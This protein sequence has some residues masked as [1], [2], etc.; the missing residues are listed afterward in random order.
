MLF[1][2]SE[3]CLR[4]ASSTVKTAIATFLEWSFDMAV[5]GKNHHAINFIVL[6]ILLVGL[7]VK[8]SGLVTILPS[9]LLL[10]E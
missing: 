4:L 8:G 6:C 3:D 10:P 5:S 9:I 1:E 2:W 7:V